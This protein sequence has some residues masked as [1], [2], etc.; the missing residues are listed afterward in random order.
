MTGRTHMTQDEEQFLTDLYNDG[1]SNK[2]IGE[3]M[4][5]EPDNIRK[6]VNRRFGKSNKS[7]Q[8]TSMAQHEAVIADMKPMDAVNYLLEAL[9]AVIG[10]QHVCEEVDELFPN[11]PSGAKRNLL[12]LL[13]K[14]L[15][16]VVTKEQAYFATVAI[17]SCPEPKIIS[18]YICALRKFLKGSGYEILTYWG[19]GFKLVKTS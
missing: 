19:V 6:M 10:S 4:E 18:V 1:L 5:R 9:S 8:P 12:A 3:R 15:D 17:S 14:N 11:V 16:Q 13:Y 2:Q 7:Q